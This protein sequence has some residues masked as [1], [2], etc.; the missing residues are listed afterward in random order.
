MVAINGVKLT[1]DSLANIH[2]M[3]PL[4]DEPG[5]DKA[6]AYMIG[7]LT[8]CSHGKQPPVDNKVDD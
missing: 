4:L 2:I 1:E 7:L 3:A 5:R 6:L 8:G